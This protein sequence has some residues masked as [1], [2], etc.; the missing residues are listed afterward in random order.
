[1]KAQLFPKG[2]RDR[3]DLGFVLLMAFLPLLQFLILYVVVNA[4]SLLLA[5][6]QYDSP[7][8]FTFVGF[9]N[10][11]AL[12]S[13]FRSYT[14]YK[15]ALKNSA[16]VF[17]IGMPCSVLLAL[18]FSY[19]IYKKEGGLG[20]FFKMM[21]FLPSV[22]PSIA[23]ATMFVQLTDSAYPKLIKLLFNQDV[24]GLFQNPNTTI[25]TI[26]F[27][28]VWCSFGVNILLLMNA[29]SAIP[30]SMTEAA[31]ID[32]ANF[33]QVFIHIAIPQVFPTIKTLILI[34]IG[35]FFVNSASI[36]SFYGT[37]AEESIYTIGYY[38]YVQ[39][40]LNADSPAALPKLAALG[41]VLTLLTIP[42]VYLAKFLMDRFG[43]NE[44]SR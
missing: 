3:K 28:N 22:V 14:F 11:E 37:K 31:K 15:V 8:H 29:M 42:F 32:G 19:Y 30:T 13:D 27:Y 25:F 5:F 43:P 38:I 16:L 7:T 35:G 20:S 24:L 23:L 12:F 2:H 40:I 10:F 6:K 34:S 4:N 41:I 39:A 21:L 36:V 9:A 44:E 18:F 1:M 17:G 33:F 26:I